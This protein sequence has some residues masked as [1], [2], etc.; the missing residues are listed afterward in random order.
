MTVMKEALAKGERREPL[1][2]EVECEEKIRL[3]GMTLDPSLLKNEILKD[4]TVSEYYRVESL[5]A[6]LEKDLG[7]KVT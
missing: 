5:R 6:Y 2:D 3:A 7:D 4:T 1:Q